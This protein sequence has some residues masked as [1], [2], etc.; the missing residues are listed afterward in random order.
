MTRIISQCCTL[1]SLWAMRMAVAPWFTRLMTASVTSDSVC[2]S[3]EAVTWSGHMIGKAVE[4]GEG[5]SI[6]IGV[7]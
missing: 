3:N 7:Q 1:L 6:I 5:V 2:A 4:E